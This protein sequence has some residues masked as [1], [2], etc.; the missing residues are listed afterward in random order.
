MSDKIVTLK[1]FQSKFVDSKKRFPALVAGIGTGKTY[2][3]LLK[4][5]RF[6]QEYPNSLALIVRKEFTDLRDSTMKD[7]ESYFQVKVD[8][9]KEYKFSNGSIIMFRHGDEINVLKNINLSIFGIEQA[10]EFETDETFQYLRN[11]LRR[12]NAP[13]QQGCLIANACGHNWIWKYWINNKPSDE[14]DTITATTFDNED[15]LPASFMDDLRRQKVEAP[16][17]YNQFVMNSFEQV[18]ADDILFSAQSV[19]QSPHLNWNFNGS[20][21]RILAIDVARF[22]ADETVFC[23]IEKIDD[24][25]IK[26]IHQETWQRKDLTQVAGKAI[27]LKRLL[28]ID[29]IVVDDTG[30]GGGVTD[31]LREMKNRVN[32]FNGASSPLNQSYANFRSEGFF[33]LKDLF[34]RNCIKIMHDTLLQEQ[35]LTIKYKFKSNGDKAIVSKDEM[36]SE[37][38]KSPDRA[39]ALMMACVYKDFPLKLAR[40]NGKPEFANSGSYDPLA[41]DSKYDRLFGMS[42][43]RFI[44]IFETC[45]RIHSVIGYNAQDCVGLTINMDL[46]NCSQKKKIDC[47]GI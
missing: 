47:R 35:L 15:N 44:G 22:G 39:D 20:Q 7:F 16:N 45:K 36:R 4:M 1:P 38:L 11:R 13:I 6:C 10:E 46:R 34:D 2:M 17:H 30:V 43:K 9:N 25:H 19:Y 5:W 42:E 40:G 8:S 28:K 12:D 26:Q 3:L 29:L 41:V 33:N 31:M 23:A 14:Y 24:L 32:A 37:G 18:E 21:G 27:E